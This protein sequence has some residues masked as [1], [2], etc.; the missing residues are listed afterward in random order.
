MK[1]VDLPPGRSARYVS[2]I[3]VSP[4]RFPGR[5]RSVVDPPSARGKMMDGFWWILP[6]I[7]CG[8]MMVMM[9]VMMVGMGKSMFSR[10]KGDEDGAVEDVRAEQK[11]P[12]RRGQE[13]SRPRRPKPGA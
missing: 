4:R 13:A 3:T 10:D 2:R 7:G 11:R 1:E 5:L 12:L 8:L 9:L 6:A